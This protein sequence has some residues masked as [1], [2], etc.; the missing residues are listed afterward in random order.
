MLIV[1]VWHLD[2]PLLPEDVEDLSPTL[3]L[4]KK[5]LLKAAF[6]GFFVDDVE[7]VHQAAWFRGFLA[8]EKVEFYVEGSGTYELANMDLVSREVYLV[9][10]EA[11]PAS[12]P[13][14][15]FSYQ[16]EYPEASTQIER[17]LE[18]T[19]AQIGRTHRL[20]Q[21]LRIERPHR[22]ADGTVR[23]DT[24]V[25]RLIRQALMV[26]ADTTLITSVQ[27]KGFPSP[28]VCLEVG[29]ALVSKKPYQIKLVEW[30]APEPQTQGAIFPFSISD[31]LRLIPQDETDL[32]QK[33]AIELTDVLKRFR[34]I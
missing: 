4:S 23:L 21:K 31:E 1:K 6:R 24:D 3:R 20:G 15:F 33:L 34:L 9:R 2:R 30:P 16:T 8:G 5:S 32:A 28:N 18:Q 7:T 19:V 26:I 10:A 11:P 17:V 14:I 12:P 25:R 29:Y 22:L 13:L 27:G